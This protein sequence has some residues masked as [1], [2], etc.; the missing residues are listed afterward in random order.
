MKV[1]ELE[2]RMKVKYFYL[3]NGFPLTLQLPFEKEIPKEDKGYH[4]C[5]AHKWANL[6][7][8]LVRCPFDL[9]FSIL[10]I[11]D[12]KEYKIIF[13]DEFTEN[14]I[15]DGWVFIHPSDAILFHKPVFQIPLNVVFYSE[16]KCFLETSSPNNFDHNLKFINGKFDISSWVRPLNIAFEIQNIHQKIQLK[17]NEIIGELIFH[18]SKIN[19]NIILEENNNPSSELLSLSQENTKVSSYIKNTKTLISKGKQLLQRLI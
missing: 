3:K 4:R 15:K 11:E 12:K 5:Y 19:K 6:N 13:N 2:K 7:R 9:N 17:R 16:E 8:F 10:P 18:T 14:I 1:T